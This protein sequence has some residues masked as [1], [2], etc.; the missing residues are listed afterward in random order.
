MKIF[1]QRAAM[2]ESGE[3]I[4]WAVAEAL[5][6]AA[7]LVQGNHVRLSWQDVERGTFGHRHLALH[8]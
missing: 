1:E 5:A 6:S 7:L 2:I 3:D 4:Y 8:D